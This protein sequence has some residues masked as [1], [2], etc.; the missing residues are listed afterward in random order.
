VM[1]FGTLAY[2]FKSEDEDL[3]KINYKGIE[4][5]QDGSGYWEFD[6]QGYKFMTKYNPKETENIL[7]LGY[8]PINK[9]TGK[10][11]YFVGGFNEPHFE[12]VRNLGQFILRDNE[13]CLSEEGCIGDI[14]TKNCSEENIIVIKEALD[15]YENI[16]QEE[17][18]V[19]ISAS[20]GNQTKFADVF[21]FKTLGIY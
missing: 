21:L 12:I 7:F 9:Y 19:F 10:P 17:N 5:I 13:A 11:L 18:C 15:G 14:P 20:L 4:F 2:A 16:Y 8:S 6:I 3:N 1:V